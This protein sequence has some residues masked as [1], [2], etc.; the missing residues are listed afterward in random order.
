[1]LTGYR[2][3]NIQNELVILLQFLGKSSFSVQVSLLKN[4]LV[5]LKSDFGKNHHQLLVFAFYLFRIFNTIPVTFTSIFNLTYPLRWLF[6]LVLFYFI[7]LHQDIHLFQLCRLPKLN[8]NLER[9]QMCNNV[10]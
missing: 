2:I 6:S 10:R 7:F 3:S 9:M 5:S 1:M 8:K 4:V